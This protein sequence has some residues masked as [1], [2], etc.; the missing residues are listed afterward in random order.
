VAD[1]PGE[2]VVAPGRFCKKTPPADKAATKPEAAAPEKSAGAA[3]PAQAAVPAPEAAPASTQETAAPAA[4]TQQPAPPAAAAPAAAPSPAPAATSAPAGRLAEIKAR[5]KLICGVNPNLLGFSLQNAAGQWIGI[6]AD[7]CRALAAAVFGDASK[8]E[9]VPLETNE[10][11]EALKSGKIDVLS[12]NTTWTMGREVEMGL[13]F[14]GVLYF[15]GQGFMTSD[16]RGL[17]SAQQLAGASVCVEQGT[18]TA[19]NMAFYFKAHALDVEIKPFAT[20]AELVKAYLAGTC[21]AY[22][23]DRSS[24]FA[25]RAG[26]DAPDKHAVLPEVISKEPLGPVVLKAD[27]TWAEIVRWTLAGLVNAEEVGL[28]RAVATAPTPPKGEMERLLDGAGHNSEQLGLQ[29][30]WLKDAV[31]ASGN[32]GEMFD[33]NLGKTSALGMDRGINALWKRG[34]I[35]YAPPMW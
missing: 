2:F 11:F 16:E 9:F 1:K 4:A 17:V 24:L 19:D 28:T 34:G 23:G 12:R 3:E 6:D 30:T 7:F 26:F 29:R 35:L 32:Y 20:R 25:D 31:A 5:G 21:D 14:A 18:T 27:R 13:E 15:D 8:V 10:R 33:A 22:S